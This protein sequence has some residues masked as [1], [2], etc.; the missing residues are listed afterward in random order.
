MGEM[1]DCATRII[2]ERGHKST[3]RG[4]LWCGNF[5]NL[6][7]ES[8]RYLLTSFSASDTVISLCKIFSPRFYESLPHRFRYLYCC[9]SIIPCLAEAPGLA[10]NKP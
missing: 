5:V 6:Q 9:F 3:G 10:P 1:V 2:G 8:G 4:Q 7:L